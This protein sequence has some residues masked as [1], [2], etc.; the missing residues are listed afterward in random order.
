[1]SSA[2]L[3]GSSQMQID[4]VGEP[5]RATGWY[6]IPD[7]L[8]TIAVY[9]DNFIGR[10]TIE[11]SLAS[12]PTDCDWF[13]IKIHDKQKNSYVQFPIDKNNV[14]GIDGGDSGVYS[15]TFKCNALYLR[16][17]IWRTYFINPLL[18]SE[19]VETLGQV[20]KILLSM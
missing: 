17:T 1:M 18:P 3:L 15:Y 13:P 5:V 19:Q 9:V 6:G 16:A 14:T 12:N 4:M 20:R 8:H 10:I 2:I 7:G 11:G